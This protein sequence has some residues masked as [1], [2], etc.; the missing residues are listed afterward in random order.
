MICVFI[1]P[2][3]F[4]EAVSLKPYEGATYFAV[5]VY[6]S[7]TK[8][9]LFIIFLVVTAFANTDLTEHEVRESSLFLISSFRLSRG[10]NFFGPQMQL[11]EM[12]CRAVKKRMNMVHLYYRFA[13]LFLVASPFYNCFPINFHPHC[14]RI[15]TS[16][17]GD[18]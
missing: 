5:M 18:F 14:T 16:M 11:V 7:P 1:W 15:P 17:I 13:Y 2:H 4:N 12:N 9:S 10:L 8:P 3:R 6:L